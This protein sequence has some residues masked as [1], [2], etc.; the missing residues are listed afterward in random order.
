[1]WPTFLVVPKRECIDLEGKSGGQGDR[2]AGHSRDG[3]PEDT[4]SA[5]D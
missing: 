1:M 5:V 3:S 2:L 4:D